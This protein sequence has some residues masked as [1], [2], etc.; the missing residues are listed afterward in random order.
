MRRPRTGQ[1][2]HSS[3][4]ALQA[5][6]NRV[7]EL[8]HSSCFSR[9]ASVVLSLFGHQANIFNALCCPTRHLAEFGSEILMIIFRLSEPDSARCLVG[10]EHGTKHRNIINSGL[11]PL[12]IPTSCEQ[13]LVT[14]LAD[15]PHT[16]STRSKIWQ[17]PMPTSRFELVLRCCSRR[18]QVHKPLA[19]EEPQLVGQ[20]AG[21]G[22]MRS[23][24]GAKRNW[25]AEAP[26]AC[27][28]HTALAFSAAYKVPSPH[29]CR[30]CELLLL[31]SI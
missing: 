1:V 4:P 17:K 19:G 24:P 14:L 31:P 21:G 20:Q 26:G 2:L 29:A 18:I 28:R 16:R 22:L 27:R 30:L 6:S 25:Q 3:R 10:Q 15:C 5:L 23:E 9:L 7:L 11:T 8:K 13:E 12:P